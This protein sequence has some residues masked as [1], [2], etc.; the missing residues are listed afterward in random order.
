MMPDKTV[1]KKHVQ[2]MLTGLLKIYKTDVVKAISGMADIESLEKNLNELPVET[3]S[4]VLSGTRK[5]EEAL[6]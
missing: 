1:V 5:M 6:S 2:D 4:Q 3:L